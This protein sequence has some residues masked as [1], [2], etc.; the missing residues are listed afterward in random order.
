QNRNTYMRTQTIS[1]RRGARLSFG[2]VLAACGIAIAAVFAAAAPAVA[3]DELIDTRLVT[4]ES[5]EVT[6]FTLTYSNEIVKIG[7]E[8]H[9]TDAQG[10]DVSQGE[11]E[12]SGRDVTQQ[13]VTP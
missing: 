1:A 4:A 11:P 12:V 6:A 8:V 5:G 3:H 2:G 10:A 9:V 13:L 7:T